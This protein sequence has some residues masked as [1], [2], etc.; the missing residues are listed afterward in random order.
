[1]TS[2]PVTAA[3]VDSDMLRAA[4]IIELLAQLPDPRCRRGRRHQL[5]V[6]FVLAVAAV[7]GG[8]RSFT[9]IGEWAHDA[10]PSLLS[11]LAMPAAVPSESTIRR[12]LEACDAGL[13]SLLVGTWMRL[14]WD[15]LNGHKII[16]VDGKSVRG[17]TNGD[18]RAPHLVSVFTHDSG[19]VLGQAKVDSKTNEIPA[20]RDLLGLMDLKGVTVSADALHTQTE[21]AEFICGRG[22]NYLFTVKNNQ[23]TLYKALADLP[24]SQVPTSRSTQ[25][26]HGR[27]ITRSIKAI[28]CPTWIRF[29]HAGQVAQVRRTTTRNGKRSVEVVY[30]ISSMNMIQAQPATLAAWI[31]GHWGIENALHWVRDVT[32]DEDRSQ[33]R[34]GNGAETMAALR[35]LVISLLRL[36]DHDNIAAA[37]RHIARDVTR[38]AN[39]LLTT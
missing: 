17:A 7:S 9:A 1:M 11:Q 30:L 22:G 14:R 20:I 28:E 25:R 29:P 31:Q 4:N 10:G 16:A 24:W 37:L 21:T 38:A 18:Q 2:S 5:E 6:I 39:L 32:F 35:N 15:A 13:F 19:W 8:A 3:G 26:C 23:P 27:T 33:V 34:T 36:H 12:L